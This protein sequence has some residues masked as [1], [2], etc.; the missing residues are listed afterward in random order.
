MNGIIAIPILLGIISFI[1]VTLVFYY[2]GGFSLPWY[3][4]LAMLLTLLLAIIPNFSLII[5][6]ITL[7]KTADTKKMQNLVIVMKILYWLGL[8]FSFVVMPLFVNMISY[9]HMFSLKK[10]LIAVLKR[11]FIIFLITLVIIC[12]FFLF[13]FA[14]AGLKISNIIPLVQF[15]SF[16]FGLSLYSVALGV[17]LVL[18]PF[19]AWQYS[20]PN[21]ILNCT[22]SLLIK[23]DDNLSRNESNAIHVNKMLKRFQSEFAN[24]DFI[25]HLNRRSEHLDKLISKVSTKNT[26][27]LDRKIAKLSYE[28]YTDGGKK[29]IEE[30]TKIVD[31]CISRLR[32][33]NH[34]VED[35]LKRCLALEEENYNRLSGSHFEKFKWIIYKMLSI[36]LVLISIILLWGEISL[37]FNPELSLLNIVSNSINNIYVNQ[38]LF[39]APVLCYLLFLCGY[40][41]INLKI[42]NVYRFV[43]HCSDDQTL[44]YG[45]SF[46]SKMFLSIGY[47][48]LYQ[49]LSSSDVEKTSYFMV[50]GSIET[51]SY[52][53]DKWKIVS[54]IIIILTVII[55]FIFASSSLLDKLG[56][57]F[58]NVYKSKTTK[59]SRDE[60]ALNELDYFKGKYADRLQDTGKSNVNPENRWRSSYLFQNLIGSNE[61][62]IY[63]QP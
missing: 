39:N 63:N 35:L 4:S 17:G 31:N 60:I 18:I 49:V 24:K 9:K 8:V 40:S 10:M 54:P 59:G 33:S 46:F 37:I 28:D 55:T 25:H 52:I 43:P 13:L 50:M 7:V 29:G 32:M 5:Y 34:I 30:F 26:Q 61:S 3:G 47:N 11:T 48:Y 22:V 20:Y 42:L 16:I 56:S 38:L 23:E 12:M 15:L 62:V 51:V 41:I 45:I 14:K 1:L 21:V 44:Y 57:N 36:L 6:D 53:G 2:Y 58:I 19:H 27:N